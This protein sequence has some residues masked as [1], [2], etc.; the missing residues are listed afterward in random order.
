MRQPVPSTS[1]PAASALALTL[2]VALFCGCTARSFFD[3]SEV[4]SFP[5]KPL[6]VPILDTGTEEGDVRFAGATNVRQRDLEAVS[7]DYV[8]N[9][10]DL[11]YITISDL[12]GPGIETPKQV[13]VTESGNI[14]Q[15]RTRLSV[16]S[17]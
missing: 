7:T 9:K 6:I 8:I 3:P 5:A 1:R 14:S 13:R 16:R 12:Q 17:V 11:L 2:S 4:G 15:A 10:N